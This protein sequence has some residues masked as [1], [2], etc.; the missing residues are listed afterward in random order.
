VTRALPQLP[1]EVRKV[2]DAWPSE[3]RAQLRML[4]ALI[5]ATAER[6]EG[7]GMLE[8]ALRWGEPAYITSQTRS[9]ST[10]RL[11]WKPARPEHVAIYFHCRTG[12][13]GTFRTLF[14]REFVFEGN[15]AILLSIG[16]QVDRNA[17]AMCIAAALRYNL[18]R[19]SRR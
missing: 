8:E 5:Y 15:R 18:E 3:A 12:L 10:V 1:P 6:T 13:V 7:V 17:I 19:G 16:E 2:F 4:R 14:P 9:G 11:G